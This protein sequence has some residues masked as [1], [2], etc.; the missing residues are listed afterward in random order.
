MAKLAFGAFAIVL[1]AFA[2]DK[3]GAGTYKGNWAG[4]SSAGDFHMTLTPDGRAS[5]IGFTMD[6]Q[7]V[8][9]KVVSVKIDGG[10]I[11]VTHEFDLQGN[12]LQ[13]SMRGAIKGKSLEGTYKTTAGDQPVDEGTWKTA[14]R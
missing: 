6:G 7:E 2:Q 1:L 11:A 5:E 14:V 12:K 3:I 9:C 8:P 10:S 4:A 13:S